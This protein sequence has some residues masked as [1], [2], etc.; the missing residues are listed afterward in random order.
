METNGANPLGLT[1]PDK[2]EPAQANGDV[3]PPPMPPK[4]LPLPEAALTELSTASRPA[5][6][7]PD[8]SGV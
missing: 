8:E 3:A 7:A 5:G 2:D 4:P 6:V 1:V